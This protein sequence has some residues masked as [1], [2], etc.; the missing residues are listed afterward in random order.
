MGIMATFLFNYR[1]T[2]IPQAGKIID[3]T[4]SYSY[5]MEE[6]T[7]KNTSIGQGPGERFP[8]QSPQ[9]NQ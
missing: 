8:Q 6:A 2:K 5:F 7:G 4:R 1:R 9:N 3:D